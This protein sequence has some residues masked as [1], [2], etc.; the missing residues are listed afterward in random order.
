MPKMTDLESFKEPF[1]V[2]NNG[3]TI[4]VIFEIGA[5]LCGSTNTFG[6]AFFKVEDG[7]FN[8]IHHCD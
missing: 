6:E 5:G 2:N 8:G 4:S 7:S 1:D 3:P